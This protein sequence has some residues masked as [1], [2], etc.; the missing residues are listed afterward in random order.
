MTFERVSGLYSRDQH[1]TAALAAAMAALGAAGYV[2]IV[3]PAGYLR[4]RP[5]RR[6]HL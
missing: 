2:V 4:I 1:R 5:R 3:D 6:T